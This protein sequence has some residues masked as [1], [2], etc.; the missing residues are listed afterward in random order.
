MYGGFVSAGAGI[1]FNIGVVTLLEG[2]GE[3]RGGGR[4]EGRGEEE[5]ERRG[6]GR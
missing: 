5:G 3:G 1:H 4:E 6:G 2:R